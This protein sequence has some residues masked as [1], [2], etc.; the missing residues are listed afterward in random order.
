MI[1]ES[2]TDVSFNYPDEDR[3]I[4]HAAWAVLI[5]IF[6]DEDIPVLELSL[7]MN[8]HPETSL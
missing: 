1:S 2:V 3:G 5:H 7:D 4:D 6:P 8:A